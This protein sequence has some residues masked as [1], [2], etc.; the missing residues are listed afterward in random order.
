MNATSW[1]GASDT[2]TRRRLK[3]LIYNDLL[4]V[5][6][7]RRSHRYKLVSLDK[8]DD[9]AV[10]IGLPCPES[11]AERVALMAEDV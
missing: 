8:L 7:T 3:P 5:D 4:T 2:E 9:F 1:T 11:I 10:N 6:D